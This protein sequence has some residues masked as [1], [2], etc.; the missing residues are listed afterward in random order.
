M[1]TN[2]SWNDKVIVEMAKTEGTLSTRTNKNN[3]RLRI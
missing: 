1:L 3:N 2:N